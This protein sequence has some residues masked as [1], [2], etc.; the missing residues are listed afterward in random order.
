MTTWDGTTEADRQEGAEGRG[1]SNA[2]LPGK[3][4]REEKNGGGGAMETSMK[5]GARAAA[6]VFYHSWTGVLSHTVKKMDG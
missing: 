3:R 2:C 5:G 1:S 4:T 6:R